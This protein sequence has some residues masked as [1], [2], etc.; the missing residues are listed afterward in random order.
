MT[1]V[2]FSALAQKLAMAYF[3][4]VRRAMSTRDT[5]KALGMSRRNVRQ[6]EARALCK[7]LWKMGQARPRPNHGQYDLILGD[8]NPPKP[9]PR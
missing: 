6:A 4:H 8:E 9:G 2:K 5:A 1:R 7:L 3:H